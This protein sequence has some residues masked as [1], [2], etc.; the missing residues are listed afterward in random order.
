MGT[1]RAFDVR[2]PLLPSPVPQSC[3][4]S[5]DLPKGAG[6]V[7]GSLP[8]GK[9]RDSNESYAWLRRRRGAELTK[10]I[11]AA[12]SRRAAQAFHSGALTTGHRRR[13]LR[14]GHHPRMGLPFVSDSPRPDSCPALGSLSPAARP[15]P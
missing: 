2:A 12:L 10:R 8:P 9:L 13:D 5:L 4:F 1:A 6:P 15:R 14:L 3:S 7:D 11:L